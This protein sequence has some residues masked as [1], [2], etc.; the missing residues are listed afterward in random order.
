MAY[1]VTGATGF[2]GSYLV[3][4]LIE[5]GMGHV[6]IGRLGALCTG[7]RAVADCTGARRAQPRRICFRVNALCGAPR[8]AVTAAADRA[9]DVASARPIITIA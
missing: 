5:R 9:H 8:M 4:K 3:A 7:S 2:I 6:G 1:F